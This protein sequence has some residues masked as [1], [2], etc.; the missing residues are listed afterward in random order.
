MLWA[1]SIGEGK[2]LSPRIYLVSIDSFERN[3]QRFLFVLREL[4]DLEINV[5][6][7]LDKLIDQ[8][9]S[10]NNE[11]NSIRSGLVQIVDSEELISRL[12]DSGFRRWNTQSKEDLRNIGYLASIPHGANFSVPGAGKTNSL[13]ALFSMFRQ[14]VSGLR[15]LVVL[16]KNAIIS[17]DDEISDCLGQ[18][19]EAVR[20]TGGNSEIARK[21][22]KNPEISVIS[23]QQLR[24]CVPLIRQFMA[25][26][27]VH[28]VLDESHRIKGGHQSQQGQV[29][30]EIANYAY[31]RDILSGTPMPQG[32]SDLVSQFDF[33]WPQSGLSDEISSYAY[34]NDKFNTTRESIKNFY[35]RTTK[36]ELGLK[37]PVLHYL[38]VKMDFGQAEIHNLIKNEAARF[39]SGLSRLERSQ[40]SV[41]ANQI[42]RLLQFSSDPDLILESAFL[43]DQ[44]REQFEKQIS[45][46]T[47]KE[48]KLDEVVM[49]ILKSPDQKVV[50]WSSFVN[51]VEKIREKYSSFGSTSIHGGINTGEDSDVDTREGR[52]R[53]FNSDPNC[54]VMVANPAACGEG[55]S[56]H[57]AA[58]NAIYF[59]R[60]FNA[61]HFLQSIDRIHRR[62]LPQDIET[63]VYILTLRDTI[64]EV[65]R[66]RLSS[67]VE[68]LK[69]ILADPSLEAM[70]YDP[71]DIAN[72]GED[73]VFMDTTDLV[74]IQEFLS[75]EHE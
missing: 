35:V 9:S 25:M 58:H 44:I 13:L 61:A 33:L 27:P 4:P 57:K 75:H 62:G 60:N 64:D 51:T 20:L 23:Y 70:V 5:D 52:I 63:N 54:R 73:I 43:S 24:N 10:R 49:Q 22:S 15:L 40:L 41:L 71:E 1:M 30:L 42:M 65:V 39:M 48:R 47:A 21:L 74:S 56:L 34:S 36:P 3:F 17:W 2:W 66:E 55:I 11:V 72:Y 68:A 67:K 32:I 16:P 18:E 14:V 7:R 29:A 19:F 46:P 12:R 69:Q 26:H 59:D 31:R 50:I 45:R 28:L 8:F 38:E 6:P 53:A 37:D